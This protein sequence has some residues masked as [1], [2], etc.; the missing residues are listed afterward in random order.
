MQSVLRPKVKSMPKVIVQGVDNSGMNST[1]NSAGK[2]SAHNQSAS[3]GPK[4]IV[5]KNQ[6]LVQEDS[7]G[8]PIT[9][10]GIGDNNKI[11]P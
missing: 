2:E 6:G 1:V 11:I 5:R 3:G 4:L 8:V 9:P 10:P 7:K